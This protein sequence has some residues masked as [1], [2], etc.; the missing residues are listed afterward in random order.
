[1]VTVIRI[2]LVLR[3]GTWLKSAATVDVRVSCGAVASLTKLK[4]DTSETTERISEEAVGVCSTWSSGKKTLVVALGFA[5]EY[6]AG[7]RVPALS[8]VVSFL[9]VL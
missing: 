3:S 7:G 6:T 8:L 4:T 1:M 2:G 5:F 9:T